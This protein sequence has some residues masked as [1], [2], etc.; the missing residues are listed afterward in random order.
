MKSIHSLIFY[1]LCFFISHS[2]LIAQQ[3]PEEASGYIT[4]SKDQT[5]V[6][7]QDMI[8]KQK[9]GSEVLHNAIIIKYR[10]SLQKSL[11]TH[12]KLYRPEKFLSPETQARLG[13]TMQAPVLNASSPVMQASQSAG[14]GE[15]CKKLGHIY[16]VF[17]APDKELIPIIDDLR[18]LPEIEYA[19]PV[20]TAY[21]YLYVPNDPQAQNPTNPTAYHLKTIKAYEAW[22]TQQGNANVVIGITD[23]E[24]NLSLADLA[25]QDIAPSGINRDAADGDD[26]LTGVGIQHG[27]HVATVAV[28]KADNGLGSAG[29]CFGCKMMPVKVSPN[30]NP[31]IYTVGYAGTLLAAAQTN[32][33][34]VNMSWGRRG[35]PSMFELDFLE[36]IVEDFDVVLVAAAGNDGNSTTFSPT[37]FFY[38]ASYDSVVL[39]VGATNSAD[40]KAGFSNYNNSVD[41][42]APGENIVAQSGTDSGT[43]FASPIVAGV[44][45]LVRAQ[46]PTWT[47][48]QVRARIV[49]TTDNIYTLA[50]NTS[51]I[52][53]LGSGRVNAQRAL[54]D[55]LIALNLESYAFTTSKRNH[56]FRGMTSDL[57]ITLR[58]H[59][60][61][62]SNVQATLTTDSPFLNVL[63]GTAVISTISANASQNNASDVFRLKVSDN[64]R[65]NTTAVLTLAYQVGTFSYS[66]K[67][68]ILLNPGRA[69]NNKVGLFIDDKG[70]LGT[71]NQ[72]FPQ[73]NGFQWEKETLFTEAGFIL[74]TGA[75]KVS[76]TVRSDAGFFDNT[77]VNEGT[78][79]ESTNNTLLTTYAK[80]E[81]ITNNADRIGVT[82][83]Q[84]TYSWNEP[85]VDKSVV[86]EYK[87]K[88]IG[89]PNINNLY[90]AVFTNWDIGNPTT[91]FADW[92]ATNVMGYVQEGIVNPWYGGITC[93]TERDVSLASQKIHYYAFDNITGSIKIDDSFTKAEKFTAVS[94]GIAKPT[95]GGG[96]GADVANLLGVRL[97]DMSLGQARTVAFAY[98]VG[99]SLNDLKAQAIAIRSRY[100]QAKTSPTPSVS[101]ITTCSNGSA[102]ITPTGGTQFNFY[103]EEPTTETTPIL[104]TGNSLTINN[105]TL[106]QTIWVACVD[107][108]FASVA[109]PLQITIIPH[110]T[111][112]TQANDSLNLAKSQEMAFTSTAT[113]ATSWKWTIT[114]TGG[115]ANA[116][117]SFIGGTSATVATPNVK[118]NRNG[119]FTIKLA[120]QT[121]QGCKDSLTT[122][123]F[124]YTDFTTALEDL[125]AENTQIYPNPAKDFCN[126]SIAN[127]QNK[128]TLSLLNQEGKTV[129]QLAYQN[130]PDKP[131]RLDLAG[132]PT[133]VYF[134]QL[135]VG[136]ARRVEKIVIE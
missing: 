24:F 19:E 45:G 132:L 34:V 129:K 127:L 136:Q 58:N 117:I 103:A 29:V 85:A 63:D 82:V 17:L 11:P 101:P 9:F 67:I 65:A 23:N 49:S 8:N 71:T 95:A 16:I 84:K 113:G 15:R 53:G 120:T 78:N 59:L 94:G 98:V 21:Q 106:N 55:P 57:V 115:L 88:N 13:I 125:L 89:S 108:V 62:V 68:Y 66:E 126:I 130:T 25:G 102:L 86:V 27:T 47:A 112:F 61:A 22:D 77:F 20:Y 64:V 74:A 43:S 10:A 114:R 56:L 118:F 91:N 124:V 96:V 48:K 40:L 70:T 4:L 41:L 90:A 104:H 79:N 12:T 18:A 35:L 122:S 128:I 72:F 73:F 52:G 110:K 50:G 42:C 83:E 38:P 2:S 121:A 54:T 36:T 44:V 14:W 39:S 123:L 76:N 99:A 37:G 131:F 75:T 60:N 107:S 31:N 33:R 5:F 30:S 87:I 51:F 6:H 111:T 3:N 80:Y 97:P 134:V 1:F 116:D 119:I 135:R 26:V 32:C 100:K 69:D 109:V 93:L 105:I 133:G 28:G 46:Y 92:D 7:Q 81:D